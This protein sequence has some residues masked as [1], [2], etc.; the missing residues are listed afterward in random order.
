MYLVTNIINFLIFLGK[1]KYI[2][3]VEWQTTW[4]L[5]GKR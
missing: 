4:C 3:F 5:L 2:N 1:K